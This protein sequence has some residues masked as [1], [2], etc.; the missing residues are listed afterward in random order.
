VQNAFGC[1]SVDETYGVLQ[2][3]FGF[4]FV[5]RLV[6]FVDKLSHLG[7][8]PFIVLLTLLALSQSFNC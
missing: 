1:N 6:N 5:F 2:V 3:L 8:A 7:L 4:F